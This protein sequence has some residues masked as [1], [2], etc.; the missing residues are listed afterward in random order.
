MGRGRV[1]LKRIEN[2]VS[3]QVTFSKR[4]SGLLKK[5]H[6]ISVL[7]EADVALIIFSTKG[8]LCDMG[9]ILE[10][11][12][13]YSFTESQRND[14][15]N[16]FHEGSWTME[17][18]ML[19]ARIDYLEKKERHLMGQDLDSLNLKELQNLEQ[20]LQSAVRRLNLKKN[21]FMF[22][23]I[24][25]LQKKDKALWD[26]NNLLAKEIKQKENELALLPIE[27]HQIHENMPS[28]E[29]GTLN[30]SDTYQPCDGEAE[31]RQRQGQTLPHWMLQF[32][33]Q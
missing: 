23:S 22:E 6:E 9:K 20:K 12:D 7:C 5:A 28:L 24:S 14:I 26:Q 4:R 16:Q 8:K 32:M 33:S 29:L 31:E 13:Q 17:R 11:Y 21:Q 10:R 2:K 1:T 15:N 27:E 30:V 18:A 19:N 25:E 3:R